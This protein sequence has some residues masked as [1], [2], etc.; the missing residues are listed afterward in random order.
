M[1]TEAIPSRAERAYA[2]LIS[3]MVPL[4]FALI[5]ITAYLN[6]RADTT[7]FLKGETFYWLAYAGSMAIAL[8]VVRM[9]LPNA[10]GSTRNHR[11]NS[12][13]R[14][15]LPLFLATTCFN[16]AFPSHVNLIEYI[17]FNLVLAL[18]C[19]WTWPQGSHL[20]AK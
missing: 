18:Y 8:G 13:I 20:L 9:H 3:V 11:L 14:I 4:F 1:E 16:W 17:A 19:S 12:L 5:M 2:A 7:A 15:G 6:N 10:I